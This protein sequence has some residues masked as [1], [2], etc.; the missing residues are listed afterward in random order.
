ML[1]CQNHCLSLLY[2]G[3]TNSYNKLHKAVYSCNY[4]IC[5]NVEIIKYTVSKHSFNQPSSICVKLH[6]LT[7]RGNSGNIK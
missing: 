6:W 7:L 3:Y 1:F 4:P 2:D 5:F